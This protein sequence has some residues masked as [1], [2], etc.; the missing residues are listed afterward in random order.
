[1]KDRDPLGI[2]KAIESKL[3]ARQQRP[4]D[5]DQYDAWLN[6]PVTKRLQEDCALSVYQGAL[7]H[8]SLNKDQEQV[9]DMVI[10]WR[11]EELREVG[12][13]E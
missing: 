8:G 4:I 12:N 11:P 6:N 5:R 2:R 3:Q 10:N 9:V 13:D 1:M 7:E